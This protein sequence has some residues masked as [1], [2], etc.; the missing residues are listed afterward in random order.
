MLDILKL[1]PGDVFTYKASPTR[2]LV[3]DPPGGE[4]IT[5]WSS[6]SEG[7]FGWDYNEYLDRQKSFHPSS[8]DAGAM[9][10]RWVRWLKEHEDAPV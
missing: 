10:V 6:S 3:L 4:H 9:L 2:Y 7:E 8:I 5:L 1:K